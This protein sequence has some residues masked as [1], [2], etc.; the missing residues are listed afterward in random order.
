MRRFRRL[1]WVLLVG[2]TLASAWLVLRRSTASLPEPT[3][4][5]LEL[6]ARLA[7]HVHQLAGR[8]GPRH[9]GRA[10]ALESA[11]VYIEQR[12]LEQGYRLERQT[13]DAA[14]RTA[15]NVE[16]FVSTTPRYFVVGAHY[17][18]VPGTPGANDNASGVAVLL[19]LARLLRD[20]PAGQRVRFV[21][22]ANEEPPWFQTPMMGSFVYAARARTRG[23]EV[24]GMISLE[25]LGYYSAAP[26]SQEYPPP[27]HL[28]FP[29]TGHFLAAVSNFS[30][31]GLLRSFTGPFKR[32]SP[33]SLIA[34]PA[35]A[36][37]PGVG[38]SDHWSFWQHGFRALMLTDTALY[39]YPHYHSA[40]DMPEKLD[41]ARLAFATMGV[42][43]AVVSLAEQR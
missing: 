16:A 34:S 25:T 15:A 4:A 29:A 40:S 22:F 18:T 8:I 9:L 1:G 28:F 13:F 11:A 7:A 42:R 12:L 24:T 26:R 35:P 32:A 31:F 33:L 20:H 3:P 27:F 30:S 43:E 21:A 5:A 17:D 36:R 2:A 14:G 19:E 41:Y 39:R 23:D 38:W 10:T 37:V 6:G